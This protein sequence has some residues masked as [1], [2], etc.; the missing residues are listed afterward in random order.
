MPDSLYSDVDLSAATGLALYLPALTSS[1][2]VP[3]WRFSGHQF[4]GVAAGTQVTSWAATNGSAA[5][6]TN[7]YTGAQPPTV[8]SDAKGSFVRFNGTN[9][10]LGC[11]L[12][13]GTSFVVLAVARINSDPATTTAPVI[14][15]LNGPQW[16]FGNFSNIRRLYA[17]AA[18]DGGAGI[19][20]GT[21]GGWAISYTVNSGATTCRVI[22]AAANWAGNAGTNNPVELVM[23]AHQS[24]FGQVDLYDLL[25]WN[26]VPAST[27]QW[28]DL[29]TAA[30]NTWGL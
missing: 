26:G 25:I 5:K 24:T 6:M 2:G 23:G 15:T 14:G 16:T 19:A 30:T 28:N 22:N 7:A 27:P 11:A 12:S 18:R 10:S 20:A 1:L 4:D 8:G 3:S 29:A 17:G 9:Q 21:V 13:L